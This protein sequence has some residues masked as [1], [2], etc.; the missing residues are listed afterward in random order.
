[1]DKEDI[2]KI[3]IHTKQSNLAIKMKEV[4]PPA[5]TWMDFEG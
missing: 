3:H 1:M 4:L 2:Y 5:T